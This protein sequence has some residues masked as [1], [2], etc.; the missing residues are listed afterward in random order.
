MAIFHFSKPGLP[1]ASSSFD[2]MQLPYSSPSSSFVS[3][4]S[5]IFHSNKATQSLSWFGMFLAELWFGFYFSITVVVRW[6][7]VFRSTF[8][9]RLSSRYVEETLPGVYIFVC[10]ADPVIE[11]PTMV[12]NTVLSV[13]AYDY[14][15]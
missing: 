1:M 10:T 7:T 13:M 14:P 9:N 6:N 15:S 5:P 3:I 11:P 8:K 4:D 12:I 2:S